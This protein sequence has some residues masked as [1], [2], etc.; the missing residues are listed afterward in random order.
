MNQIP[1]YV[2]FLKD[3][4][5]N[6]RKFDKFKVVALNE[7]CN[8]VLKNKIPLKEKDPSSFTIPA[9]IGEKELSRA[10]C[11]LGGKHQLNA[12][13]HLQEVRDC[14]PR[15]TTVTI[16]LGDRSI[17]SPKGKIEEIL[18]QVDEFI[19]PGNFIILD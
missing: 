10:L 13:I 1:N 3:V 11:N 12:S 15:S 4:L 14:E 8:A 9:T 16:Q 2:K 18:I 17:T 7:E 6:R 5:T 19:F